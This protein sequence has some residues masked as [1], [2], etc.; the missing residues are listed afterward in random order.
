MTTGRKYQNIHVYPGV[1]CSSTGHYSA[2]I[3]YS[4]VNKDNIVKDRRK[5]WFYIGTVSAL[6]QYAQ[7]EV[8]R[9]L[10]TLYHDKVIVF[11]EHGRD[12]NARYE[13]LRYHEPA[14][15]EYMIDYKQEGA[16]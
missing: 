8:F 15:F 16:K 12:G 13:D 3:A 14:H 2:R 11:Y 1:N 4:V 5:A 10:R 6:P 9:Q 7:D